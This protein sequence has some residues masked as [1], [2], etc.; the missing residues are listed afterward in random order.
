MTPAPACSFRQPSSPYSAPSFFR[1]YSDSSFALGRQLNSPSP[2]LL[3]LLE[4]NRDACDSRP[5]L[6]ILPP[7]LT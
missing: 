2:S 3:L 6:C 4:A 1:H 7:G 5:A